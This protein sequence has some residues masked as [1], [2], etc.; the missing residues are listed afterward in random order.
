MSESKTERELIEDVPKA[1][2]KVLAAQVV[3]YRTLGINKALAKACMVELAIRRGNG[4]D[5]EYEDFIDEKVA[6]IPKM[7]NTNL[8]KIT[9]S[10][11]SQVR[12]INVGGAFK[13]D[14]KKNSS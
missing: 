9:Q 8:L 11:Q 5:F 1:D 2:S 7:Q 14:N 3:V 6:G 4:D 10:I 12:N 13:T